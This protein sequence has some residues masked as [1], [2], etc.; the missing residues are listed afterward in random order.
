M[1]SR[2]VDAMERVVE[3]DVSNKQDV[4]PGKSS[5]SSPPSMGPAHF[6]EITDETE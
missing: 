1:E 5:D 4:V 3:I 2:R 6:A